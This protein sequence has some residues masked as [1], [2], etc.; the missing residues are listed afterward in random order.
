MN[1]SGE[2]QGKQGTPESRPATVTNGNRGDEAT[3][4]PSAR[5][6]GTLLP[7]SDRPL[8]SGLSR[9][10]ATSGA[11]PVNPLHRVGP[12][13]TAARTYRVMQ[14]ILVPTH[15]LSTESAS[16]TFLTLLRTIVMH[17]ERT[18]QHTHTQSIIKQSVP[19]RVLYHQEGK[20]GTPLYVTNPKGHMEP[21]ARPRQACL[22]DS[23]FHMHHPSGVRSQHFCEIKTDATPKK[24]RGVFVCDADF[25][26]LQRFQ[27]LDCSHCNPFHCFH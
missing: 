23:R 4:R 16:A 13:R 26:I 6:P 5:R 18:H 19:H 8:R 2:A 22:K 21:D 17:M 24:I 14:R 27:R 15:Q 11:T 10:A 20:G 3:R 7:A 9:A 12:A 25:Q 1:E